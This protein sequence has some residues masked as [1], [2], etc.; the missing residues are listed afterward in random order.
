MSRQATPA[1][2]RFWAKVNKR[3]GSDS[4][5]IWEGARGG[6]GYGNFRAD[7][8]SVIAAHTYSYRL[9]HGDLPPGLVARHTCNNPLCVRPS[10][11]VCGTK[12]ENSQD[13]IR[14]GAHKKR[15]AIGKDGATQVRALLSGG[16]S[17]SAIA[18]QYGVTCSSIYEIKVGLSYREAIQEATTAHEATKKAMPLPAKES[19]SP[20]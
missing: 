5:W 14:A 15:G 7:S 12:S 4:C 13:A 9:A 17:M 3:D 11:L 20:S 10:H 2:K 6:T 19:A 1:A 18:R 8:K 16:A